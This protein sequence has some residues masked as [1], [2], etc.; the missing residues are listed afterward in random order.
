MITLAANSPAPPPMLP[1]RSAPRGIGLL[2]I[3]AAILLAA[4]A[5][6]LSFAVP[7]YDATFRDFGVQLPWTTTAFIRLSNWFTGTAPEQWIPGA[8]II[9]PLYVLT[10]ALCF[11]GVRSSSSATRIA[12]IGAIATMLIGSLLSL[13]LLVYF[14]AAP[15]AALNRALQ[16]GAT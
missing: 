14:M 15:L 8:A 13:G 1:T 16:T 10:L 4:E 11:V 2:L 9:L 3:L 12:S 6:F 5:A 7:M